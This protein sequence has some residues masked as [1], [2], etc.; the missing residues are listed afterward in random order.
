M[1]KKKLNSKARRAPLIKSDSDWLD[2]WARACMRYYYIVVVYMFA[3]DIVRMCTNILYNVFVWNCGRTTDYIRS[4]CEWNRKRTDSNSI[5]KTHIWFQ[6][7]IQLWKKSS[8]NVRMQISL[9]TLEYSNI[10]YVTRK[11]TLN[12]YLT[13][14]RFLIIHLSFLYVHMYSWVRFSKFA[15]YIYLKYIYIQ[16][17]ILGDVL[18]L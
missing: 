8:I 2:I 7:C 10:A 17:R 9:H 11:K 15:R 14:V 5:S 3:R 4:V 1:E 6:G 12:K 18:K 16:W 13:Y